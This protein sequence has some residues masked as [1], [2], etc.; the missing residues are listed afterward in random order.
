[1]PEDSATTFHLNPVVQQV[2]VTR[3]SARLRNVQPEMNVSQ[4]YEVLK[5][6]KRNNDTDQGEAVGG[7]SGQLVEEKS[8][9][10]EI[11]AIGQ[12][13]SS[14]A[15][16]FQNG[17]GNETVQEVQ[18]LT[19]EVHN[20]NDKGDKVPFDPTV[21]AECVVPEVVEAGE[22]RASAKAPI[23]KQLVGQIEGLK[24]KFVKCTDGY[25]ISE[26]ERLYTRVCQGVISLKDMPDKLSIVR[27][28]K[29]FLADESNF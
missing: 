9:L 15:K 19:V 26:L 3:A 14:T 22:S 16:T 7:S 4:S 12:N 17:V 13:V 18:H 10:M 6:S 20:E 24:Q 28:L 8:H 1:L 21:V 29:D 25:G 23:S 5:R 2:H 11:D 27:F